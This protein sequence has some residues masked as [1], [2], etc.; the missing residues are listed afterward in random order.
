MKAWQFPA[1]SR[2]D[3]LL[4]STMGL[5]LIIAIETMLAMTILLMSN[6]VSWCFATGTYLLLAVISAF[7]ILTQTSC[8][9]FGASFG[10]EV[11][12]PIDLAMV[13]IGGAV[14]IPKQSDVQRRRTLLPTLL[15]GVLVGACLV[16]YGN[17]RN[18]Q[19]VTDN[20][21]AFFLA[22][23]LV[24]KRWPLDRNR[25]HSLIEMESG[26]WLVIVA[27]E[28]CEHCRKLIEKHFSDP[29][30]RPPDRRIAIFVAGSRQWGFSFDLVLLSGAKRGTI[31]WKSEPFVASPAIFVVDDGQVV[32]AADGEASDNFIAELMDT[33]LGIRP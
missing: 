30:M 20:D 3:G 1:I 5:S 21:L 26:K 14:G 22:D 8:N 29:T 18:Y 16:F 15:L 2:G 25:S 23:G 17:A 6:S 32:A 24:G 9:C 33:T 28:E 27:R 4:G 7:S 12:L 11:T 31:D 13:M 10:A 19:A